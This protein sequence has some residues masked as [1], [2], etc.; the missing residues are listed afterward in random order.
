MVVTVSLPWHLELIDEGN[1]QVIKKNGHTD[2]KLFQGQMKAKESKAFYFKVRSINP[3]K[4]FTAGVGGNI[5]VLTADGRKLT[6]HDSES[7]SF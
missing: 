2:I 4:D 5:K 7:L 1:Y 6:T 3:K